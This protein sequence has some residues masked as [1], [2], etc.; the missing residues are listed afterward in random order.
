MHVQRPQSWAGFIISRIVRGTKVGQFVAEGDP[1]LGDFI[2]A[3][4]TL[5]IDPIEFR[6]NR[7]VF[8]RI[9]HG[10]LQSIESPFP[11]FNDDGDQHGQER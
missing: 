7:R 3:H 10:I 4:P 9:L 11:Q 5:M 1:I 6:I 2:V 8:V